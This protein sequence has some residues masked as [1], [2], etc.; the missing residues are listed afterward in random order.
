MRMLAFLTQPARPRSDPR[1]ITG[2]A[3]SAIARRSPKTLRSVFALAS[4]PAQ[5]TVSV[6][7]DPLISSPILTKAAEM[8]FGIV[9]SLCHRMPGAHR[10]CLSSLECGVS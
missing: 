4:L 7:L 3:R 6:T 2:E 1:R 8:R 9:L 5:P 10:Y